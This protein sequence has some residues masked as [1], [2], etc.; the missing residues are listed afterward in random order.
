MEDRA[1]FWHLITRRSIHKKYNSHTV[2]GWRQRFKKGTLSDEVINTVLAENGY[3][4]KKR[5]EW[6]KPRK[7]GTAKQPPET[8]DI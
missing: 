4:L 1:A 5:A 3:V 7:R 6:V 2:F 8:P